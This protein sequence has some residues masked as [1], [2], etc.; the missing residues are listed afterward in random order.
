MNGYLPYA[1]SKES[2][3]HGNHGYPRHYRPPHRMPPHYQSPQRG[4]PRMNNY[5]PRSFSYPQR[6][7]P[8]NMSYSRPPVYH[9]KSHHP[10]YLPQ[11]LTGD[12]TRTSASSYRYGDTKDMNTERVTIK[13]GMAQT[14]TEELQI[15]AVQTL[16]TQSRM[17]RPSMPQ[18]CQTQISVARAGIEQHSMLRPRSIHFSTAQTET[19]KVQSKTAKHSL[20]QQPRMP[21][22]FG[23]QFGKPQMPM[24]RLESFTSTAQSSVPV[25]TQTS[26]YQQNMTETSVMQPQISILLPKTGGLVT[27]SVRQCNMSESSATQHSISHDRMK[28]VT[29]RTTLTPARQEHTMFQSPQRSATHPRITKTSVIE[30]GTSQKP[31]QRPSLQKTSITQSRMRQTSV[32]PPQTSMPIVHSG[33]GSTKMSLSDPRVE[34]TSQ[35]APTQPTSMVKT[36]MAQ[37]I[38]QKSSQS[39]QMTAKPSDGK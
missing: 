30:S 12:S 33:L 34:Q 19:P 4:Y 27:S 3:F 38:K 24:S 6:V 15:S 35:A 7:H 10:R 2:I 29:T 36:S 22:S 8:N 14:P 18:P 21:Q 32:S 31:A 17:R 11:T 16:L 28:E 13:Q 23:E 26:M 5:S 39:N 25:M 20:E 1:P 37:H 9:S